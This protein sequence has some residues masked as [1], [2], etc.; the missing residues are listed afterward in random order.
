MRFTKR[1]YDLLIGHNLKGN[2]VGETK[3][4]RP[5]GKGRA[6]YRDGGWYE[7]NWENGKRHGF[8]QEFYPDET[9]RYEGQWK[10]GKRNGWGKS[11]YTNGILAY[12]GEWKNGKP[13]NY[14]YHY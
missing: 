5:H 14:P 10:N 8:G 11:Y 3:Y 7:G 2:Y 12:E 9:L 13:V 1:L 6:C 4:N